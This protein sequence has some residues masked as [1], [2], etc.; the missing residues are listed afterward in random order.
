M[1]GVIDSDDFKK[2]FWGI[3][4]KDGKFWT[5]LAFDCVGGAKTH[6]DKFWGVGKW[7]EKDFKVVPVRIRLEAT[8]TKD[9]SH[10]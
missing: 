1:M 9:S 5:P 6:L 7:R 10:D 2:E 8:T 4:N 3:L